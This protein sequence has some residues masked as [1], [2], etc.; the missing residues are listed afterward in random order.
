MVEI[1]DYAFVHAGI[2]Q[3][4]PL[5]EQKPEDLRWIRDEFLSSRKS[6][7]GKT[8]VH[9]HTI[10]LEVDEHPNRLGHDTG[11]SHSGRLPALCL[12]GTDS[13]YLEKGK[14]VRPKSAK[15]MKTGIATGR[16]R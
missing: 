1:G 11:A 12:Q 15:W 4:V 6:H 2:K 10:M 5:A 16:G 8:V 14:G 7:E 3:G 9:G 13:G